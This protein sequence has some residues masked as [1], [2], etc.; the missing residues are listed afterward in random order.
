MNIK[1]L[2]KILALVA[3]FVGVDKAKLEAVIEILTLIAESEK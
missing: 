1:S 3:P 2:L